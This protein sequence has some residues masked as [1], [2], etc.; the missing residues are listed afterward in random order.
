ML[1]KFKIRAVYAGVSFSE[2]R[3]KDK[4]CTRCR[5]CCKTHTKCRLISS[6]SDYN[7]FRIMKFESKR[8]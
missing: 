1:M 5:M 3:W 6:D 7:T 4:Q 2:I 8:E